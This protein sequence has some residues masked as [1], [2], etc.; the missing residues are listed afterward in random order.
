MW[1]ACIAGACRRVGETCEQLW[2]Q[3][4]PLSSITR[5]M[6]K[7]NYLDC[8]DDFFG[9]VASERLE[10]FVPFMVGQHKSLVRKLGEWQWELASR[11]DAQH[12][13]WRERGLDC[14]WL[15]QVIVLP[16]ALR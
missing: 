12:S 9:F 13:N 6:A 3:L 8:I 10:E 14:V 5:Y 16:M 7:P 15:G 2:A 1:T 4:K 11:G